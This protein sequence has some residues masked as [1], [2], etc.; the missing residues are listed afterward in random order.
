MIP[1]DSRPPEV[2]YYYNPAYVGRLLKEFVSSYQSKRPEGVSY[3]LIFVAIPIIILKSFRDALPRSTKTHL[4]NWIQD[5]ADYKIG[6][7]TTVRELIPFVKESLIFLLQRNILSINETGKLL[8]GTSKLKKRQLK[9]TDEIL[10]SINKAKFVGRW[11][12]NSGE[13]ATIYALWGIRL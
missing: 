1:W 11:F 9:D 12:A 8:L 6:F 13:V 5:N 3:E 10:E 4:H 2:A 7:A